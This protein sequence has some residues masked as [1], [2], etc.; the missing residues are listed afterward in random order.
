MLT[1]HDNADMDTAASNVTRCVLEA[2]ANLYQLQPMVQGLE[3]IFQD[4]NNDG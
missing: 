2:G 1:L 4:A 3:S